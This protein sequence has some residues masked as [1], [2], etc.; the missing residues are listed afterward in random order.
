M[1]NR[2]DI[3]TALW[4]S[5]YRETHKLKSEVV[6]MSYEITKY[7]YTVKENTGNEIRDDVVIITVRDLMKV[8]K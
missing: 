1:K 4:Y 8:M 7:F 5:I 3:I 2:V 6:K